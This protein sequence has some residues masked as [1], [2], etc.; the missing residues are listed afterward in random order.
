MYHC[1]EH[2]YTGADPCIPCLTKLE[3]ENFRLMTG[4][5]QSEVKVKYIHEPGPCPECRRKAGREAAQRWTLCLSILLA[6]AAWILL[7]ILPELAPGRSQVIAFVPAAVAALVG[8][9]LGIPTWRCEV[10]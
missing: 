8:V 5:Q 3:N 6:L 4:Q 10:D 7:T 9:L 1:T 2:D